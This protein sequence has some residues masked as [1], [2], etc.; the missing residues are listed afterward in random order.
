[1]TTLPDSAHPSGKW[2]YVSNRGRN[3]VVLFGVDPDKGTLAYIEEQGTGGKT[4]RHFG[5]RPSAKHMAIANQDSDT[6]LACRIDS[7]NGRLKP[8]AFSRRRQ[9]RCARS[10]CRRSRPCGE[11]SEATDWQP[12]SLT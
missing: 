6:L 7:G 4:R 1:V 9:R 11:L 3:S 12:T 5:I 8:S 10:F 2:I